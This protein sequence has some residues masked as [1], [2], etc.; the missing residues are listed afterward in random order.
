MTPRVRILHNATIYSLDKTRP[1]VSALAVLS[2][3]RHSGRVLATGDLDRLQA[4]FPRAELEDL[5]GGVVLPGLTDA[6]LHLQ[7]YAFSLQIVDCDTATRAECIT[8]VAERAMDAQPGTWIR[9]HGWRQDQW[10]EGFGT[11]AMLSTVTS[12][13]TLAIT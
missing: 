11:A 7:Q 6:H 2:E 13:P 4:E 9:G 12:T 3:G 10:P 8:R 1:K 5:Q